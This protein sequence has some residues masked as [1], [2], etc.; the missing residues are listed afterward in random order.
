LLATPLALVALLAGFATPSFAATTHSLI[1]SFGEFGQGE[2]N[3]GIAVDESTGNVFVS[4]GLGYSHGGGDLQIFGPTGGAPVGGVVAT[5]IGMY[6]E[7]SQATLAVDNSA[8]SPSKGALYLTEFPEVRRISKYVLNPAKEYEFLCR[9]DGV[10]GGCTAAGGATLPWGQHFYLTVDSKGDLFVSDEQH[11][12]VYELGPAG[13]SLATIPIEVDGEARNPEALAV[14]SAGDLFVKVFNRGVYRYD[15]NSS[16]EIVPGTHP[17]EF[18]PGGTAI[19][20]DPANDHVYISEATRIAEYGPSGALEGTFGEGILNGGKI[21]GLAVNSQTGNVYVSVAGGF[22]P[23][24]H[25]FLFGPAVLVPDATTGDASQITRTAATLNGTLNAAGGPAATCVFEYVDEAGFKAEGFKSAASAPC[26][27]AGPF[28]GDG[29]EAVSAQIASLQAGDTYHFRLLASN[30]N[31]TNGEVNARTFQ[32]L[33]AVTLETGKASNQTPSSATLNGTITP[34]GDEVEECGFEYLEDAAFQANLEAKPPKDG[35]AGAA[36]VACVETPAE[37]G[38]GNG[39][40]VVHADISGLTS[41]T[42][43][44]FRLK[45]SNSF[46]DTR[47]ED[48]T[49]TSFGPPR[50]AEPAISKIAPDGAVA[51]AQISPGGA[52]TSYV[53]QYV[54]EADFATDEWAKAE[55]V[56][57]GGGAI[58]PGTDYVKVA[59][60]LE[61][62]AEVTTY[63]TRFLATNAFGLQVIGPDVVFTTYG[64]EAPGLPDARAYEQVTPVDK[65]GAAPS[66]GRSAVQAA[67]DGEG[68]TYSA[69]GAIP[70]AEGA[71]QFPNYLASRDSDWSSQ[72]LLPPASN[73]A[74]AAV[75]GWSEDLAR[76]YIIQASKL[77][78]PYSFLERDSATHALR[79]IASEGSTSAFNY[80]GAAGEGSVV[81]FESPTP[82]PAGGAKDAYNTYAW[83]RASGEV[84]LVGILPS[85]TVAK[86]GSLAGSNTVV[87]HYHYTQAQHALSAD[88]SR[89]FFNDPGTGQLYLRVNPTQPQSTI[90]AK[91]CTEPE[92]ACSFQLSASKRTTAPLKDEKASTFQ[93]ATPDGSKAF[94]TSP[95][96]LTNDA[97]TGPEDKGNDLYRYDAESG[98]LTNLAPDAAN[99]NGADVQGVLGIAEDGSSVYFVANGDLDGGGP[100]TSGDC[101]LNNVEAPHGSCGLYRWQEGEGV[102]FIAQLGNQDGSNRISLATGAEKTSRVSADG[103]ALL[104]SSTQKLTAYDN[105]GTPELYRYSAQGEALSCVSCNPTNASPVGPASLRSIVRTLDTVPSPAAILTRNL[106]ADGKR[107][108][109]ETPDKLVASDTNGDL[110]CEL[111]DKLGTV[112]SCQD[113]YE[114]EAEG[115]GSCHSDLQNGGCLYLISSG[116]S[117]DP[118]YF[119]D[120]DEAGDNAFFFTGESLVGQDKDQIVDIYDARVGGGIAS[121][122][123]PPPAPPCEGEACKPALAPAPSADSPGSER[124]SGG[125]QAPPRCPKGAVRKRGRC[126]HRA[127]NRK[128]RHHKQRH[129]TKKTEGAR[130]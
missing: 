19:A 39:E 30:E 78:Q 29:E 119:A 44:D 22:D 93:A 75:M 123:P 108:F 64:S 24:G 40:V 14:N 127:T 107:V 46:G 84:S 69:G 97:T 61:G 126:V 34:A 100:A 33:A 72:G 117:P 90:V 59:V 122:S 15:A 65:N 83:D 114:W 21:W 18:A 88:G 35:F 50:I 87:S 76:G 43:Y 101:G 82:L 9:I 105:E 62:L 52:D 91:S 49:F 55:S 81:L 95:G 68:I 53:V 11:N 102:A 60:A 89:A 124:F 10:G 48:R 71:Q 110:S 125:N 99:P 129:S 57:V 2:T 104:F 17:V 1:T 66:G 73:G 106:S 120:A 5:K 20:T 79:T 45:A 36:T 25:I 111:L 38:T 109:F 56:P 98:Q 54:S 112:R 16:G 8:T 96:K 51:L 80:A 23:V 42:S 12:T 4:R 74:S 85:G 121:Q 103:Q 37:I 13:E 116:T 28:T 6:T 47:G 67:L 94:F 41:N 115:S 26:S 27:P 86:K 58:A 77:G 128:K 118:S 7:G 92:L 70:G 113:V 3:S 32:A 63:H 31:G 130:R